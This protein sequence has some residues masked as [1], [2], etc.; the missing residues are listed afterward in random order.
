MTLPNKN[1][2]WPPYVRVRGS[3]RGR[4]SVTAW[5]SISVSAKGSGPNFLESMMS[6]FHVDVISA[7]GSNIIDDV[8]TGVMRNKH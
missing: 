4:V 6:F 2:K 1:P 3:A 5:V 7:R 8:T